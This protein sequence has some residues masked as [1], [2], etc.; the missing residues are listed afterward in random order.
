MGATEQHT[1][2]TRTPFP[3]VERYLS[4]L[5]YGFDS[6]PECTQRASVFRVFSESR[7]LRGFAWNAVHPKIGAL[8]RTPVSPTSW[9]TEVAGISTALAL[10]DH[11]RMNDEEALAWFRECNNKLLSNRMYVALMSL[12]SPSLLVKHGPSRWATL[13]RGVGFGVA[14]RESGADVTLSYPP[15]LYDDLLVRAQAEG[16]RTALA[17]SRAK[18]CSY[19]V[20]RSTPRSCVF[21]FDWV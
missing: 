9:L 21:R 13:H 6:Y 4:R 7:S 3:R 15:Y 17:M 11:H 10:A 12:A 20:V 2:A 14:L 19:E 1:V 16:L 8:L 18:D 5:P